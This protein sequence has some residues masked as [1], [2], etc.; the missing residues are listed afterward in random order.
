MLTAMVLAATLAGTPSPEIQPLGAARPESQPT[1]TL[2]APLAEAIAHY[3]TLESYRVVIHSFH[4]D[5]EEYIRYYYKR[6]GYVRMEFI[7]PHAG[8]LLIY[9]PSTG[10]VRLW[11]FGYGH[12]PELNLS[13]RNPLIRSPR[14]QYVNHSDVGALFENTALLQQKGRTEVLGTEILNG[15]PVVHMITTGADNVAI[16]GVHRI[17]MWLDTTT[18][19]PVRVV[20]SDRQGA[21]I[22]TVTM[23][24]LELNPSVPDRLF[25]P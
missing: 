23:D 15:R 24:A 16:D 2:R 5:G 18:G 13:P 21:M 19:F 1:V 17:E 20:S 8:A 25:N 3:Q 7:K 4:G 6:P 12:F 9:S 11:P 14:G 22:E 10:R